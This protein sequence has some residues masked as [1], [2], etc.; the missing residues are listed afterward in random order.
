M[1]HLCT[2]KRMSIDATTF[3]PICR[4]SKRFK[5]RC[6]NKMSLFL[7]RTIVNHNF[8]FWK[9]SVVRCIRKKSWMWQSI[10]TWQIKVYLHF[11]GWRRVIFHWN[12]EWMKFHFT[13][14]LID[15]FYPMLQDDFNSIVKYILFIFPVW[16]TISNSST[17]THTESYIMVFKCVE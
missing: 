10:E 9:I 15:V 11:N 17:H 6:S 16:S 7:L 3:Q 1:F 13:K 8:V 12:R 14:Y 4:I 2:A 5:L